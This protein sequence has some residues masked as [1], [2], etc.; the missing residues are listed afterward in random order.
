MLMVIDAQH[1]EWGKVFADVKQILV[2][3]EQLV[4]WMQTEKL[5]NRRTNSYNCLRQQEKI[6]TIL[7][8]SN[9][10]ENIIYLSWQQQ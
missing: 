6:I 2:H 3:A 1:V 10:T 7:S 5:F 4:Q 8:G 9:M